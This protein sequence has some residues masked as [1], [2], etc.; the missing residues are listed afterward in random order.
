MIS[1]FIDFR[2]QS[3]E[4]SFVVLGEPEY[5]HI[6]NPA[7]AVGDSKGVTWHPVD[8]ENFMYGSNFSLGN[9]MVNLYET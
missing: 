3:D 6:L 7:A 8:T 4:G 1:F 9:K 5:E 2:G